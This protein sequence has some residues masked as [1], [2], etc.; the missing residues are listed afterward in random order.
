MHFVVAKSAKLRASNLIFSRLNR[1]EMHV[2][3]QAGN[4]VLFESHRG[5]EE[6]VDYIVRAKDHFDL[7]VDRHHH[8]SADHIVFG[9]WIFRIKAE[10]RFASSGSIFQ[11]R[12]GHAEFSVR[13]WIAEIPLEL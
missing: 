11:L 1:R 10:C 13:P 6:A 12:L 9:G 7:T 2:D 5:N 3:G 8:N 4:G